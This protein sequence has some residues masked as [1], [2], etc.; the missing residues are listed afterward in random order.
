MERYETP[1]M[2]LIELEAEDTIMASTGDTNTDDE[3][4]LPII[5]FE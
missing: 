3:W 1:E 2:E 5:P 4:V